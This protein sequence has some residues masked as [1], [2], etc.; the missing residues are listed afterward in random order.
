[1]SIAL[2]F[3]LSC[4]PRSLSQEDACHVAQE[5][6]N[7]LELLRYPGTGR[8]QEKMLHVS[9]MASAVLLSILSDKPA[10]SPQ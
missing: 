2:P 7:A 1:M 6:G 3:C 9:I 8:Q 5:Q 10:N 4:H